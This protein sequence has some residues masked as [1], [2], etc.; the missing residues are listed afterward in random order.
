MASIDNLFLRFL[1]EQKYELDSAQA[2]AEKLYLA[3]ERG[4]QQGSRS[5]QLANIVARVNK[6]RGEYVGEDNRVSVV[7]VCGK[8]KSGKAFKD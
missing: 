2:L 5:R 3:F 8:T 1:G 6:Q 7:S 4:Y